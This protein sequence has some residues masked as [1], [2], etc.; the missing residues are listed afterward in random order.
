MKKLVLA[1]FFVAAA[2]FA[3]A[4]AGCGGPSV[5]VST[6]D[7]SVKVSSDGTEVTQTSTNADGDKVTSKVKDDGAT[8]TYTDSK[9]TNVTIGAGADDSAIKDLI[10]PGA[11]QSTDTG[12]GISGDTSEGSVASFTYTTPDDFAK[13]NEHYS[14]NFQ[15]GTVTTVDNNTGSFATHAREKGKET[16]TVFIQGQKDGA[17]TITI[18]RATKK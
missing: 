15:G 5:N 1:S 17:T 18:T 10:Y 12:G 8:S 9:G 13:V 2:G 16:T 7:G 11:K 14:K 4:L 3:L 6:P